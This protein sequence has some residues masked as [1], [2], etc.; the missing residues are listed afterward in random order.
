MSLDMGMC[1]PDI[2]KET[3][4]QREYFMKSRPAH[5]KGYK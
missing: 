1:T 4:K 2:R 3:H 5:T